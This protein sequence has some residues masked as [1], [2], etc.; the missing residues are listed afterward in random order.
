VHVPWSLWFEGFPEQGKTQMRFA[1]IMSATLVSGLG[2]QGSV[3]GR[4][5][6]AESRAPVAGAEVSVAGQPRQALSDSLGKFSLRD[7]K[8]GTV[9]LI[10]RAVGFRPDTARV[11]IF[12]DESIS[13]DVTLQ[14]SSTTLGTVVVRDSMTVTSAKLKEFEERRHSAVGGRFLD[15][16]VIKKWEARKT[17]DLLS[18]VP[19][20]DVQRQRSAAYLIGGRATQ[21]LRPSARPA[22]CFMDIYLDGAPLAMGNTPFDVNNISLPHVAAVEV[23]SGTS[24]VPARYNRTSAG[25]GVVLIWTK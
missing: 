3:A 18:T 6:A 5:L 16:T 20:V 25:C 24:S 17:G 14:P 23:Y 15:S 11:E 13:R 4:V 2:A 10:T 22:P 21:P 8:A 19:G 12:P 1:L 7:V 9:Y